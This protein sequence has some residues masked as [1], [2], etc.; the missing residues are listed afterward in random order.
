VK[1]LLKKGAILV[2]MGNGG[3]GKTTVAAALG[4][5]AAREGLNTALITVDPARRL[6]EALGLERLSARPTRLDGRRLRAAGLDS[7]LRL[8]A[9]MLDVKRTWDSLVDE[10]VESPEARC[11]ILANPFY[12]SLTQQFAGA[13]AYAALEQLDELHRSGQFDI[14]IVDTP[15]AAH[16]FEFF[17]APRHL[18]HLLDSPAGRWL[19]APDTTLSSKPP[20]LASRAARFVIAQVEAFTGTR[21]LSAV[22]DFFGLA[23]EAAAGLSERFHRTEAMMHSARVS[24]V[25][26]TTAVEDRLNEALKLAALTEQRNF[27]LRAIVINRMLDE[28]TFGALRSTRRRLPAHLAEIASLRRVLGENDRKLSALADYLEGYRAQQMLEVERA[29][30]FAQELPRR[31]DLAIIPAVVPGVRDLRA[32]AGLA[33]ILASST[34]GRRFLD[35]ADALAVAAA[36]TARAPRSIG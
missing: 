28:R 11:R 35:N 34:P 2:M 23:G 27:G 13:E 24:F 17:E 16:A 33:S 1:E 18:I 14:Q 10:L 26:V 12:R 31:I 19:F 29:V 15:P 6:R 30:R 8:S 32:L 4:L 21:T 36:E 9:L 25:L 22:S 7:S 3:V 20:T 5:A